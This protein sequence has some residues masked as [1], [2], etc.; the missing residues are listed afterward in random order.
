MIIK[1][2]RFINIILVAVL[3]GVSLAIWIGFNPANLPA[4]AWLMQQQQM[5]HSLRTL[6]VTLVMVSTVVTLIN[7]YMNLHKKRVLASLVIAAAFL[8]ACLV[9]TRLGIKTLDDQV[10]QWNIS[11]IP[12]DWMELRDRW[13]VLHT[14]RTVAE[15][16]ALC[17]IVWNSI[18][19]P[20]LTVKKGK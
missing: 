1:I 7:A 13:R 3:A 18:N 12:A 17:L 9:I 16:A 15:L 4:S 8:V 14:M 20:A 5:L 11:S 19:V 10:L 6:M 2:I